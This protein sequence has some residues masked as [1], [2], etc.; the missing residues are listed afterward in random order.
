MNARQRAKFEERFGAEPKYTL[1]N[2]PGI[3]DHNISELYT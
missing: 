2:G 3:I 1:P